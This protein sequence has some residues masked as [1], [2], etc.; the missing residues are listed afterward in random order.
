KKYIYTFIFLS[1][2]GSQ[3]DGQINKAL[4]T[5]VLAFTTDGIAQ[6]VDRAQKLAQKTGIPP[7]TI[8]SQ[9][10]YPLSIHDFGVTVKY[11][12]EFVT[13]NPRPRSMTP[14]VATDWSVESLVPSTKE[15]KEAQGDREFTD[16]APLVFRFLRKRLLDI[17]DETYIKSII[18]PNATE[19][20][21]VL[22]AK[23]GEGKKTN[24]TMSK[25]YDRINFFKKTYT[26]LVCKQINNRFLVKTI[27][28]SECEYL[29]SIL[30]KYVEYLDDN[31]D[32]ALSLFVGLHSLRMYNLTLYFVVIENI[33][34]ANLKPHEVYDLKGSW[35]ARH[36]HAGIHSGVDCFFFFSHALIAFFHLYIYTQ[37]HFCV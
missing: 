33:F 31:P 25:C 11:N 35:I 34:L 4:R 17:T 16:F 8:P 29:I 5:E 6:S 18:P 12:S 23:F 36:T 30:K 7:A 21:N 14:D 28:K 26:K 24:K 22:D 2:N 32:S 19:Q 13:G 27:T 20:R 10:L 9:D 15:E 3:E 37:C 1:L